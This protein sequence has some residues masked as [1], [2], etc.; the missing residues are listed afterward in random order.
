[1][2][3]ALRRRVTYTNVAMTLALVFAMTG[4]AY[5]AKKYLITSTKQISPKV[6]KQLAGK[7]GPAGPAGAQGPAG[8]PGPAGPQGPAGAN[9]KDGATGKDGAPGANG[10]SV[11]VVNEAPE[12]CAEGGFTYEVE[13]S[14]KQDE[15][16]NGAKGVIHPGETLPSGASETGTWATGPATTGPANVEVAISFPIPLAS[17]LGESWVEKENVA[18]KVH[19]VYLNGLE[20]PREKIYNWQTFAPEEVAPTECIGSAREPTAEPGNLCVYEDAKAAMETPVSNSVFDVVGSNSA[21]GAAKVGSILQLASTGQGGRA[22]G[23]WAVTA[24]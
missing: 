1:M 22:W 17:E 11:K 7:P 20:E 5:A 19:Y 8:S 10:K 24:P 9:G 21:K 18:N 3:T 2:L 16:C 4:G 14:G 6:L 15:V 12:N 23:S 13:G